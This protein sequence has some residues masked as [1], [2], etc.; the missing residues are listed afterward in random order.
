MKAYSIMANIKPTLLRIM[1]S[2]N[3]I[4]HGK[5]SRDHV[6]RLKKQ[7]E[8]V[9][10]VEE[11]QFKYI[12]YIIYKVYSR[13]KRIDW[14]KSVTSVYIY[15]KYKTAGMA[16]LITEKPEFKISNINSHKRW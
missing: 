9:S 3:G 8:A 11:M 4:K 1:L 16:M 13:L 2:T 12:E 6:T 15:T 10:N 14:G 5:K 7:N